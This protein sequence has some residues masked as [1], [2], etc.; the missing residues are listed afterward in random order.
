M[1]AGPTGIEIRATR[2]MRAN[3]ERRP[4]MSQVLIYLIPIVMLGVVAAVVL[5]LRA[6]MTDGAEARARSNRMMQWRVILQFAAVV[7]IVLLV[8]VMGGR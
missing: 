8:L 3:R 6:F 1:K 2:L 5:G 7:M 4:A